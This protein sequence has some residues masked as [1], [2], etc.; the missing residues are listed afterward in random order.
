MPATCRTH[1]FKGSHVVLRYSKQNNLNTG[2]AAAITIVK[3]AVVTFFALYYTEP[4]PYRRRNSSC[5]HRQTG[6]YTNNNSSKAEQLTKRRY[7][8]RSKASVWRKS[9]QVKDG[10]ISEYVDYMMMPV[11]VLQSKCCCRYLLPTRSIYRVYDSEA[12]KLASL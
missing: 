7:R 2:A 5:H 4:L 10:M 8:K 6:R 9:P 12:G 11:K 1:S 3:R